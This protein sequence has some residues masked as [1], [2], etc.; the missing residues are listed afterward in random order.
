MPQAR[1]LK[2]IQDYYIGYGANLERVAQKLRYQIDRWLRL[3]ERELEQEIISRQSKKKD[4]V[5]SSL[6]NQRARNRAEASLQAVKATISK[7]YREIENLTYLELRELGGVEWRAAQQ[8]IRLGIQVNLSSQALPKAVLEAIGK[9]LLVRGR[10]QKSWWRRQRNTFI[11]RFQDA[12]AL[13]L[14]QGESNEQLV[15]R[16]LGGK[17]GRTKIVENLFGDK[18]RVPIRKGGV[19]QA[20][21]REALALIRTSVQTVSNY[22]RLEAFKGIDIVKGMEALAVLDGRTTHICIARSR[23][24]WDLKGRPI[25]GHKVKWPGYPPWHWQ[26]RTTLVP[27]TKS[28]EELAKPEQN[29]IAKLADKAQLNLRRVQASMNGPVGADLNYEQW[30]KTQPVQFQKDVL[31]IGKYKLWK[32]GKIKSLRQLLDQD[33][34][35]MNLTDLALRYN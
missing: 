22:V 18:E 8:A 30:L 11:M 29:K 4:N 31:G 14:I 5:F 35:P 3:A 13:G 17:T 25:G 27:I 32:Q 28:F 33:G 7:Y 21:R 2:A 1:S 24:A 23:L 19:I 20:S 15:N 12:L 34:R 26:C 6:L 10:T 16:V 9:D